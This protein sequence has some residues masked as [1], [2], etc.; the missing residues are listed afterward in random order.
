MWWSLACASSL[1][2]PSEAPKDPCAELVAADGFDFP[3]GDGSQ[4][5]YYDAQPF[6][7]NRH[8][9]SDWNGRRGGNTDFGDA[10]LAIGKGRVSVVEDV[11]GGWGLVVRV[12]HL[13]G[14][15]CIESLYAH[16][17][18]SEVSMGDLVSRGQIIGAIGDAGGIYSAHLHLEIRTAPGLDLGGGYG[19]PQGQIDPTAFIHSRRPVATARTVQ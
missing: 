16:L 1:P 13:D 3:I 12:V 14:Q 19:D 10:V 11:G 4:D 6:G 5:G 18:S 8:L 15:R 17:S 9:G 2:S 7:K